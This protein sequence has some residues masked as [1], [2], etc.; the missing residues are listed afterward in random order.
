MGL[1]SMVTS[2]ANEHSQNQSASFFSSSTFQR[3]AT[4]SI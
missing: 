4:A 1:W 3:S 2:L